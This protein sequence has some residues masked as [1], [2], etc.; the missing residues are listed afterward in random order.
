M[1]DTLGETKRSMLFKEKSDQQKNQ[2]SRE[3][4]LR[5]HSVTLSLEQ[6]ILLP[7]LKEDEDAA[8]NGLNG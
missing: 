5:K 1:L 6:W 2:E 8:R 3:W 7:N 4:L